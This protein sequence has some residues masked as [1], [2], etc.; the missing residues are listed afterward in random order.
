MQTPI[1]NST[2][3]QFYQSCDNFS[4]FKEM[5]NWLIDMK[6]PEESISLDIQDDLTEE[7]REINT[8]VFSGYDYENHHAILQIYTTMHRF[9]E[10]V[11]ETTFADSHILN[12]MIRAKRRKRP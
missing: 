5:L 8:K 12:S 6:I 7:L 3:F 1:M 4:M 9:E 11:T 10:L 2:L